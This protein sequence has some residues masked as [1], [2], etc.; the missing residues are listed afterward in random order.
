MFLASMRLAIGAAGLSLIYRLVTRRS[1]GPAKPP[2]AAGAPLWARA[3]VLGLA[4]GVVPY[5]LIAWGEIHIN[6]GAASILNATSPLFSALFGHFLGLWGEEERLSWTRGLGL[7]L[8]IAGV[9]ALSVSQRDDSAS[10]EAALQVLG[11]LAVVGGSASYAV[12]AL[13]ARLAFAGS[14]ALLPATAQNV[15][16]VAVLLPFGLL[17]ARPDTRV[18]LEAAGAVLA[19]GGFGTVL[20]YVLYYRVMTRLGA[21]G[22]LSVTYLLPGFALV[23]GAAFLG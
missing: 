2:G 17:F 14:G 22:V 15:G 12:G 8:G 7:G 18:S 10:A 16:G 23:Y 20:A 3:L 13:Y 9:A 21:T 5:V 4:G 19:L 11:C 6:S 1:S